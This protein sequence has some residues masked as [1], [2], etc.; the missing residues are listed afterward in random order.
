MNHWLLDTIT[1][2][3]SSAL[4]IAEKQLV[5]NEHHQL[6]DQT[7]INGITTVANI[8]AIAV[9]ELLLDRFEEDN[10]KQ[11]LLRECAAD[12]YRLF[13]RVPLLQDPIKAAQQLLKTSTLAVFGDLEA[14]AVSML[15][16]VTWPKLPLDS[17]D[18]IE[19]TWLAI[20]DSWLRLIRK[21]PED[22]DTVLKRFT[23]LHSN[24]EQFEKTYL[25][26]A[27]PAVKSAVLEL[28]GLH[29]LA[30]AAEIM[31]QFFKDNTAED[32]TPIR[33]FLKKH[34]DH[35][36]AVCKN[37]MLLDLETLALP[38]GAAA[39]KLAAIPG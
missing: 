32:C 23:D 22:L 24:Q 15:Q 7:D 8:L 6:E 2:K 16:Q 28:I 25:H 1:E 31:A 14:D 36:W 12:A 21:V 5:N 20:I 30:K 11:Q 9:N 27:G 26:N 10:E 18:W 38:L 3:R 37:T 33:R 4:K 29:H 17:D 19:Q 35:A 13:K 34:F 39:E